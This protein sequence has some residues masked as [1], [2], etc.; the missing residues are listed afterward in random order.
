MCARA[1]QNDLALYAQRVDDG[2]NA[3]GVDVE[4]VD[5]D[6]DLAAADVERLFERGHALVGQRGVLAALA[7]AQT[8]LAHFR[9]REVLDG[10][11]AVR[12]A[13]E[14]AVVRKHVVSVLRLG[15]IDL[16]HVAA[17]LDRAADRRERIF[18]MIAPV[19]AMGDD[20]HVVA[21]RAVELRAQPLRARRLLRDGAARRRR[22]SRSRAADKRNRGRSRKQTHRQNA[23]S[24][25]SQFP[26][27]DKRFTVGPHK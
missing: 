2:R 24:L 5:V 19:A 14:L 10:A 4:L 7:L 15:D 13:V 1:L 26:F 18:R 16:D 22:G 25:H 20:E 23:N 8:R 9:K 11:R 21:V 17:H 12:Y 27:L 3:G 6:E